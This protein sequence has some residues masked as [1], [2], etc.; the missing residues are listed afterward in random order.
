MYSPSELKYTS[1]TASYDI[2]VVTGTKQVEYTTENPVIML[3]SQLVEKSR[4]TVTMGGTTMYS[5]ISHLNIEYIVGE[6]LPIVTGSSYDNERNLYVFV[7][8]HAN[9]IFV[10]SSKLQIHTAAI[11]DLKWSSHGAY[12]TCSQDSTV[13]QFTV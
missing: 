4:T 7:L 1:I 3:D 10:Q 9:K 12:W 2:V 5:H 11:S 6:T 13:R 8:D